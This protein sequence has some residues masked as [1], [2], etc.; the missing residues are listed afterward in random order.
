[1]K[2]NK[3]VF[4]VSILCICVSVLCSFAAADPT[5]SAVQPE[6]TAVKGAEGAIPGALPN[7]SINV[8]D[9]NLQDILR[10]LSKQSGLNFIAS[11]I[12]RQKSI[13]LYMQDV[14]VDVALKSIMDV[15]N[16]IYE[17]PEGTAM[18]I[19]KEKGTEVQEDV[20]T[21][22]RIFYLIHARVVNYR[23][24]PG[25]VSGGSTEGIPDMDVEEENAPKGIEVIVKQ[26]LSPRGSIVSDQR[27]NSLIV[28]DAEERMDEIAQVITQLDR[29]SPQILVEV[30][31]V[32]TTKSI[33]EHI[34]M[35]Y[36]SS[37]RGE[38]INFV[39]PT[40]SINLGFG[41]FKDPKSVGTDAFTAGTLSAAN[42]QMVLEMFNSNTDTDILARPKVLVM[43]NDTAIIRIMK[44]AAIGQV[45][46]TTD[47]SGTANETQ[48]AE[49]EEVGISMRVTP[50]VNEGGYV[51]M[52]IEP[53]FSEVVASSS[54]VSITGGT[55]D[56]EIRAVQTKVRVKS[57]NVVVIGGFMKNKEQKTIKKV[58][59]FGSIPIIGNVLFT[60]K[61]E[62]GEDRELLFFI[63]PRI[64]EEGD[65]DFTSGSTRVAMLSS[66]K[67]EEAPFVQAVVKEGSSDDKRGSEMERAI[68]ELKA[69][70]F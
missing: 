45:T 42:F 33:A 1:M 44:N 2:P 25:G 61:D 15:N 35:E 38:I 57:G 54:S 4:S 32:D 14:P 40:R 30:E 69:S 46:T 8:K 3:S 66:A 36:G 67:K 29:P 63:T 65:L 27:T 26:L 13:T 17:H 60:H 49:R 23:F 22:T 21:M 64:V 43:N 18:Y 39:G 53:R 28:T 59:F 5:A 50:Q 20:K 16:L 10:T 70:G 34:G 9:V 12:I 55:L 51:T 19:I 48:S 58:P 56:P 6:V 11:D 7:I 24:K 52:L 31:V 41:P 68:E 37:T 62:E 47:T